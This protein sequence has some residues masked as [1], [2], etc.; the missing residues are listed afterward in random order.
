MQK[1]QLYIQDTRVDLFKDESVSIT[2]T[3]QNVRDIKK[4]FTE[5]TQ[6][7][8]LPAS[9]TN[10]KLFKHYYN[11]NID[12][13]YDGRNKVSAKIELNSIPFKKG[14]VKLEGV[15]LKKNKPYTYR[16]T[17]FG[18]TIN[19]KDL[20]GDDDL[21]SLADLNALTLNYNSATVKSKLSGAT[22]QLKPSKHWYLRFDAFK[23]RL[24]KWIEDKP[25]KQNVKQFACTLS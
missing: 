2:Q 16:V 10:N 1:L 24:K 22:L 25:F 3:I 5:F 4:I 6:T 18:E 17:F 14:F 9:K 21:A 7:F 23:K 8:S 12:G 15:T 20:L 13:G 19:L 11:F